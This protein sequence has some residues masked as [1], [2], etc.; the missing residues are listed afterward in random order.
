MATQAIMIGTNGER[1]LVY[2]KD[3]PAE[4]RKHR[5]ICAGI[6][7]QGDL[8]GCPVKPSQPTPLRGPY[9]YE[10]DSNARHRLGCSNCKKRKTTDVERL[11]Q[12]GVG[13]TIEDLFERLNRE[14]ITISKPEKEDPLRG[15]E[16]DDVG[17]NTIDI[18]AE[19]NGDAENQKDDEKEIWIKP[20]HPRTFIEYKDLLTRL[21]EKDIYASRLVYDQILDERTVAG[22]RRLGFIPT[23]RPFVIT[24][25]KTHPREYGIQ[26]AN[27]QW[28]LKDFWGRGG[29]EFLFILNVSEEAKQLLWNLSNISSTVKIVIWGVFCKC[30]IRHKTYMS[31][32]L[33]PDMIMYEIVNDVG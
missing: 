32:L 25:R 8:C 11:D 16:G 29:N 4:A 10:S 14:T 24:A 6:T 12:S 15:E 2:A 3:L 19:D 21:S 1:R 31:D 33:K 17:D 22:Y 9:F 20:R 27:D 23:G 18:S 30:A 7:P 5:F 13:I 26:L 28:L